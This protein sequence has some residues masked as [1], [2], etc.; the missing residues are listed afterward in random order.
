MAR[1]ATAT[2]SGPSASLSYLFPSAFLPTAWDTT[3]LYAT[4]FPV[5]PSPIVPG[6]H[7]RRAIC[8]AHHLP[9]HLKKRVGGRM[10]L[11]GKE[12]P[13]CAG[14]GPSFPPKP[15]TSAPLPALAKA[16]TDFYTYVLAG[17]PHGTQPR[18]GAENAR[19]GARA[20]V[21]PCSDQGSHA[22]RRTLS[23]RLSGPI[24]HYLTAP[25]EQQRI[26]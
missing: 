20:R 21:P 16:A 12:G 5:W 23:T 3:E 1:P 11:G 26:L 24:F 10:G 9:I 2:N 25:A 7:Q 17:R 4:F 14:Q 8:R 19:H 13:L 22:N 18:P 15:A 6:D